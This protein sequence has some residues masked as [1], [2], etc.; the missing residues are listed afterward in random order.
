MKRAREATAAV[1]DEV[2]EALTGE[3]RRQLEHAAL[4]AWR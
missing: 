1:E 2:L 3:E 4:K